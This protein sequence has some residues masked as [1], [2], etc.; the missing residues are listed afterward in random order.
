MIKKPLNPTWDLDSIFPGGSDSPQFAAYLEELTADIAGLEQ[1]VEVLTAAS[2]T[3][4][5]HQVIGQLQAIMGK[6][7]RASA[8]ISC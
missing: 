5:W 8:F 1:Q 2:S 6:R 7:R 3:A 4:E